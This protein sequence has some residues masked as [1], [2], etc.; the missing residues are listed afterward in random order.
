MPCE[1]ECSKDIS[2]NIRAIEKIAPEHETIVT[3]RYFPKFAGYNLYGVRDGKTVEQWQMVV[4][5]MKKLYL[6]MMNKELKRL[7]VIV[8]GNWLENIETTLEL[9]SPVP[10]VVKQLIMNYSETNKI[11]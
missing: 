8:D 9:E 1:F 11:C 4:N 10:I 7:S 5:E 6:K 3:A 2:L